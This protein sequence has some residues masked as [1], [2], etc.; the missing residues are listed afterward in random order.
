MFGYFRQT[1]VVSKVLGGFWSPP[2]LLPI[3]MG[4]VES[5][6]TQSSHTLLKDSRA[7]FCL[8]TEMFRRP[9]LDFNDFSLQSSL[10][11]FL[12]IFAP[13]WVPLIRVSY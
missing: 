12:T 8:H 6:K 10:S 11:N 13:S 1:F 4:P 7:K 3:L 5:S 2:K 9:I